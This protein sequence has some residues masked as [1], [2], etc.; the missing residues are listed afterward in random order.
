MHYVVVQKFAFTF[1]TFKTFTSNYWG[2]NEQ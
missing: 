2:K 1:S